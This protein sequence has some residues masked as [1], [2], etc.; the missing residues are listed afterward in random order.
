MKKALFFVFVLAIA[1][2][3]VYAANARNGKKIWKK[4]CRLVCH[5][6]SKPGRPALS[7]VE[8]TQSQ[9]KELF[10]KNRSAIKEIHKKGEVDK[11]DASD[12]DDMFL[13]LYEHALDSD[14]PE[15]CG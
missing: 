12:W 1:T 10:S 3:S 2:T 6:G 4:S 7:P 5:D 15:T 11:V 13:Y 9:W 8:M 14:Q